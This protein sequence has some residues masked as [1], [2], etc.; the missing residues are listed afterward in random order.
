M[1]AGAPA[2]LSDNLL[3]LATLCPGI[4][5]MDILQCLRNAADAAFID[6]MERASLLESMSQAVFHACAA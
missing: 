3:F 5:R 6:P 4:T 1:R 2:G